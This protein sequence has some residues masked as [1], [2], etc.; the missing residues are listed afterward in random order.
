MSHIGRMFA[1]TVLSLSVYCQAQSALV[2]ESAYAIEGAAGLE[3]SGLAYC[4][5]RLLLVSDDHDDVVFELSP[6]TEGIATATP[7]RVIENIPLP[8]RQQFPLLLRIKRL[9]AELFGLTG[10]MDW[11]GIACDDDGT[12]Y[13]ASEYYFAVLTVGPGNN[14]WWQ[15]EDVYAS[16]RE[17][18]LFGTMNAYIEGITLHRNELLL[19][20]ER[21]PR[22][23]IRMQGG[24]PVEILVPAQAGLAEDGLSYDYTGLA[25]WKNRVFVLNRNHYKVCE[26]GADDLTGRD[27]RSYRDV[28]RSGA[29]GYDTGPYGL[30]EGLMVTD[31]A[32]W[33]VL[34]NNGQSRLS[35]ADDKRPQLFRF[36]NPF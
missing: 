4:D 21:E 7:Y 5:D 26:L 15:G 18:G 12:L 10:G 30:G 34:D 9:A 27:C 2:L 19:A 33:I 17:R 11:E 35:D 29:Y 8:P 14:L 20:V 31:E 13:L 3:P 6:G 24:T 28:E 22:A 36:A 23:L 16:G 32:I 1:V 25:V